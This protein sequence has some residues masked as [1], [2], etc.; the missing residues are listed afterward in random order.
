MKKLNLKLIFL[1]AI[2]LLILG[3]WRI[4][5][6]SAEEPDITRI[7]I[8]LT[9]SL[10]KSF[11]SERFVQPGVALYNHHSAKYIVTND[12]SKTKSIPLDDPVL[13]SAKELHNINLCFMERVTTLHEDSVLFDNYFNPIY[14]TKNYFYTSCPI[15]VNNEVVGYTEVLIYIKP[16]GLLPNYNFV[17]LAAHNIS[18][19][20]KSEL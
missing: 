2:P 6:S 8:V 14:V 15:K 19:I 11:H 18:L 5:L 7:R 13:V 12:F 1:L 20:I 16:F 9:E 4:S 10:N 3:L 17:L